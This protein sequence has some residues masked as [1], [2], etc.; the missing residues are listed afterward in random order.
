MFYN[1]S[2]KNDFC[3]LQLFL[4]YTYLEMSLLKTDSRCPSVLS[5]VFVFYSLKMLSRKFIS[6][7]YQFRMAI[8]R[9]IQFKNLEDHLLVRILHD[10]RCRRN[11][12]EYYSYHFRNFKQ[13]LERSEKVVNNPT[14]EYKSNIKYQMHL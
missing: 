6:P 3:F 1:K 7:H 5:P 9:G 2:R 4:K 10:G 13:I 12:I 14:Y 8:L 11:V